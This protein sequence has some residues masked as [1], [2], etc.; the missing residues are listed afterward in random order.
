MTSRSISLAVMTTVLSASAGQSTLAQQ[1]VPNC[2]PF[3]GSSWHGWFIGPFFMLLFLAAAVAVVVLI[4]RAL[5]GGGGSATFY[6]PP[7]FY[8]SPVDIL[9]QRFA[10][11]EIDKAEYEERLKVVGT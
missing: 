10:K 5:S 2:G 11:G 7:G 6:P 4:I 8:N 9:K 3:M 1:G